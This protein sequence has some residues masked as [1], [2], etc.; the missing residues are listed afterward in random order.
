MDLNFLGG[1]I[2]YRAN[3]SKQQGTQFFSFRGGATAYPQSG[4]SPAA[5][6]GGGAGP[7]ILRVIARHRDVWARQKHDG[8]RAPSAAPWNSQPA[9]HHGG[10][11]PGSFYPK[12]C[13][14]FTYIPNAEGVA[15]G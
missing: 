14:A 1:R 6:R 15:N 4:R 9:D 5:Y 7:G 10:G 3:F 8:V 11:S 13:G 2:R 12:T